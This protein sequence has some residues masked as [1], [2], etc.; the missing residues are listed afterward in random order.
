M[1]TARASSQGGLAQ[2]N[3]RVVLQA[4]RQHGAL[5]ATDIARLTGLSAQ[6]VSLISKRL[7]DDGLLR[8]GTPTKRG[9]VGQPSIP[10]SLNPNGAFAIGV[11]VGRRSL[12]TLLVD[13]V[14]TVR[15][16]RVQTYP[17]ADADTV[18]QTIAEH[19]QS[20][21]T[22]LGNAGVKRLQGVGMAAPLS[23]GGWPSLQGLPTSV[24]ARWERIDLRAQVQRLTPA[25][26]TLVKD[27]A[28]ACAAELLAGC[29][30]SVASYLYIFVDTFVGGALVVD[31]QLRAGPRGNAGAVGS[32]PL[33]ST[34]DAA[35]ANAATATVAPPAQLLS[36]ASLL[37]L[38]Q[39]YLRAGL[40]AS[41]WADT[42]A[43]Q[44]PWVSHTQAWLDQVAPALAQAV[45][46]AAC[47]LDLD[48]V[49]V[50]GAIDRVLRTAL[51]QAI[52]QAMQ[53]NPW[54]GVS[55]P[56]LM[57]GTLGGDARA[58]GGALLPLHASFSP[59]RA[60]FFK[61]SDHAPVSPSNQ[62]NAD[63]SEPAFTP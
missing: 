44:A 59:D 2:Y 17:Y 27:T 29:G 48:G 36:V 62:T 35:S 51:L 12:D 46:A 23:L 14:G 16:R 45:A 6:A 53:R 10:L 60:L 55:Q 7:I 54:E 32:M 63:Q 8:R 56:V 5:P 30:R 33:A 38:E 31:G 50:D 13:F 57:A 40:D 43:L 24:A 1:I 41:A 4:V 25:P 22:V 20:L 49:I 47:L 42:R 9:T 37:G 34:A 26:V 19:L 15:E 11:K 21:Q 3:E 18:I 39:R 61:G 28:A 52:D 58:L